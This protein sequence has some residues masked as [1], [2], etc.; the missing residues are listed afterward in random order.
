MKRNL[1]LARPQAA[2]AAKALQHAPEQV[3]EQRGG[4]VGVGVRQRGLVGAALDAQVDQLAQRAGQA[5]AD[6]AQRP[7]ARQVTKQHRH[8]LRPATE[9]LGAA[10]G[11]VA[12]D[13]GGE[14]AARNVRQQLTEQAGCLYHGFDSLGLLDSQF[15]SQS[16][17]ESRRQGSHSA[18]L[19]WTRVE[20]SIHSMPI[21]SERLLQAVGYTGF[22]QGT[23]ID[24][25]WNLYLLGMVILIGGEIEAGR[26]PPSKEV[27]FSY[28]FA[29]NN[30]DHSYSQMIMAG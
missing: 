10:V 12:G 9:A 29:P 13:Q 23:Q 6:L 4:P 26:I 27:V 18:N 2:L 15:K 3:L 16:N 17:Y 8:Q 19:F 1:P 25:I 24:P 21:E 22:R 20:Q 7:G 28:R 14:F 5:V 30:G 11:L